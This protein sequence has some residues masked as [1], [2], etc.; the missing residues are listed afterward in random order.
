M[1]TEIVL[2]SF[3]ELLMYPLIDTNRLVVC[4]EPGWTVGFFGFGSRNET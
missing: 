3:I 1:V 2:K 4:F